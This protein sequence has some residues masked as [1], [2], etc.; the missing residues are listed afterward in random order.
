MITC[1]IQAVGVHAAEYL[2]NSFLVELY[3]PCIAANKKLLHGDKAFIVGVQFIELRPITLCVRLQYEHGHFVKCG[4][5]CAAINGLFRAPFLCCVRRVD[6]RQLP[7]LPFST[8]RIELF[9][10]TCDVLVQR[11]DLLH[12][13]NPVRGNLRAQRF[14]CCHQLSLHLNGAL[15]QRL[16]V[17]LRLPFSL[18]GQRVL[19]SAGARVQGRF[20]GLFLCFLVASR[21]VRRVCCQVHACMAD[22]VLDCIVHPHCLHCVFERKTASLKIGIARGVMFWSR[23]L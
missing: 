14:L 21:L 11:C 13:F 6:G 15:T 9:S 22:G 17:K 12:V 23:L 19:V 3:A 10:Q 18:V 4:I 2:H 16:D 1:R 8:Q 20:G 7:L 5:Q